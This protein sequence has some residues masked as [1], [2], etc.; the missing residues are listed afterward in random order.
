MKDWLKHFVIW[1]SMFPLRDMHVW[2]A[3]LGEP[4]ELCWGCGRTQKRAPDELLEDAELLKK[5]PEWVELA[6]P[7]WDSTPTNI[8]GLG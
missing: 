5:H 3:T 1:L 2:V 8:V 6:E 7:D 4:E